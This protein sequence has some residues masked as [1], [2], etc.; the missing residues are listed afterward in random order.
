MKKATLLTLLFSLCF[1]S[2]SNAQFGGFL[3]DVGKKIVKKEAERQVVNAITGELAPPEEAFE[4]VT[5]INP[6]S[7][8]T[9]KIS[10]K[11]MDSR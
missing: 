11:D 1:I 2:N 8:A 3:K 6:R 5:L 10:S 9:P 7:V 4:E